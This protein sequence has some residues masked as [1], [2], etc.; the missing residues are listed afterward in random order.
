MNKRVRNLIAGTFGTLISRLGY[1]DAIDQNIPN[2]S[3]LPLCFHNPEKKL[4]KQVIQWL[5]DHSYS[6]VTSEQL[7]ECIQSGSETESKAV[8]ISFDDGWRGNV[9]QVIPILIE[10]NVPA[11]FYLTT[12]PIG[13]DDGTFWWPLMKANRTYLPIPYDELWTIPETRRRFI[14]ENV[15]KGDHI[16]IPRQAMTISDVKLIAA[17]PQITLGCHTVNHGISVNHTQAELVEEICKARESIFSWTG[18]EVHSFAYPRGAFDPRARDILRDNGFT[19]AVTTEAT[20]LNSQLLSGLDPFRIPRIPIP[21]SGS[22]YEILCHM[23]AIWQPCMRGI[24]SLLGLKPSEF[25]L[26]EK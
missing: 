17:L 6:F 10:Y 14:V 21:D 1:I 26:G 19:M 13:S 15:T 3:I 8:W 5:L 9:D 4:F 18:Q 20:I 22:F 16:K 24:K 23:L 25:T 11:T 2:G 12:G 7:L